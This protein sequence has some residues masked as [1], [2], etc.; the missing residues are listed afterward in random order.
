L[1][2]TTTILVKLIASVPPIP[3]LVVYE[4]GVRVIG[5][6]GKSSVE[7][8]LYPLGYLYWVCGPVV[9]VG[10]TASLVVDESWWDDTRGIALS[11]IARMGGQDDAEQA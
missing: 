4:M 11:V 9:D 2:R 8:G 1:K 6:D 5:L 10:V 7:G 3:I